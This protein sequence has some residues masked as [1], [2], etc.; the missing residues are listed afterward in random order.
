PTAPPAYGLEGPSA[1]S[2]VEKSQPASH[3]EFLT[4][5]ITVTDI[6]KT[7]ATAD[8]AEHIRAS[9]PIMKPFALRYHPMESAPSLN[10]RRRG[11]AA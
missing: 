8:K 7:S 4:L 1:G 3:T 9:F 6:I 10:W 5:P 2:T 11:N